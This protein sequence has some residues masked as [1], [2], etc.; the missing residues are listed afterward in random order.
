[1]PEITAAGGQLVAL[2]PELPEHADETAKKQKLPFQVLS[3]I[4]NR[5]ARDYG[6]VF[7]MTPEVAAAM[8]KGAKLHER[9]GDAS[10]EL[11]LGAA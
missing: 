6:V 3:D 7:R 5:V 8:Q 11:P 9:N 2:T 10:D 4:G 1:M